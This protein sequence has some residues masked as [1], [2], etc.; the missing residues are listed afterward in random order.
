M[1]KKQD[2][3]NPKVK[4]FD[5]GIAGKGIFAHEDIKEGEKVIIWGGNYTNKKGAIEFQ[6]KGLLVMQWDSD[7]YSIEER[8]KDTGYFVNHSCDS[9]LW[10][11]DAYTLVA[12]RAVSVGEELTVDYELFQADPEYHS[13]WERCCGEAT[14]RGFVTGS[15][16]KMNEL[17]DRYKDHFSPLINKL[18]VQL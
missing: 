12:K 18:I 14:C 3:K 9:N 17:Q 1:D 8:G 6:K 16:W 15:D 11:G 13:S 5:S 7:L 10:M 4:V 2:W